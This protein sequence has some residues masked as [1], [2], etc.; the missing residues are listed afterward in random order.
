MEAIIAAVKKAYMEVGG[1]IGVR[2]ED[3]N[4]EVGDILPCSFMWID[5]ERTEEELDGTCAIKTESDNPAEY[6]KGI[7]GYYGDYVYVIRG[8]SSFG[9][10]DVGERI[11]R[12]ALIVAKFPKSEAVA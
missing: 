3:R 2:V 1:D 8:S 6:L 10:E 9:G 11:Y 4:F 7:N 5:G 12:N